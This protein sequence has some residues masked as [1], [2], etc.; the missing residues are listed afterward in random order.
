[1]SVVSF[2]ACLRGLGCGCDEGSID[3][4]GDARRDRVPWVEMFVT[5]PTVS[6]GQH[7]ALTE[8]QR[9]FLGS[10]GWLVDLNHL[11]K[12]QRELAAV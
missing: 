6:T 3:T 9:R 5:V 11:A 7:Q 12:P 10:A 2:E 1:M 8:H 4:S